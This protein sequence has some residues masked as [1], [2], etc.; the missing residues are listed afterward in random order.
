MLA[1]TVK[2]VPDEAAPHVTADL[3]HARSAVDL[4]IIINK[5]KF[6]LLSQISNFNLRTAAGITRH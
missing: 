6:R 3:T 1:T 5:Y 4:R 2:G